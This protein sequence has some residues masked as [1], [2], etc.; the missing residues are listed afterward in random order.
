MFL[1]TRALK[2]IK[3][4]IL[5]ILLTS[6]QTTGWFSWILHRKLSD[7]LC[8]L[9]EVIVTRGQWPYIP[10][11][12]RT[13]RNRH[14]VLYDL[15]YPN[16]YITPN[17]R[18]GHLTSDLK[19]ASLITLVSMCILPPTASE[20]MAASKRPQRSYDLRF[21]ISNPDYPSIHVHIASILPL[22]P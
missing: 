16:K 20:A 22:R 7:S 12:T 5:G 8:C 4:T 14:V 9:I 11:S 6:G 15:N 3:H 21:D 1:S 19:S 17:D 2:G 13:M 18:G 10:A